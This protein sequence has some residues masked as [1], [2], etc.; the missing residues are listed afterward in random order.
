MKVNARAYGCAAHKDR[1]PSVCRGVVANHA[2]VDRVVL[3][4]VRAALTAPDVLAWIEQ[5]ALRRAAEDSRRLPTR[6]MRTVRASSASNA[7]L[8]GLRTLSRNGPIDCAR[9]AAAQSGSGTGRG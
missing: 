9:R 6:S 8:R 3:E 1:G 4:H 5:E 7:R 2:E